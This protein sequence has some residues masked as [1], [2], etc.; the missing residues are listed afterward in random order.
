MDVTD[1]RKISVEVLSEIES[2][3]EVGKL[4]VVGVQWCSGKHVELQ[5]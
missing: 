2:S 3:S 4:K 5:I 1:N